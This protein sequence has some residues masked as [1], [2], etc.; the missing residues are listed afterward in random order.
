MD[1]VG[2]DL[3]R[4]DVTTIPQLG[5][6]IYRIRKKMRSLRN[7]SPV[8]REAI[9]I[10]RFFFTATMNGKTRVL[11]Y[12]P[13]RKERELC[14]QC[15]AGDVIISLPHGAT[16]EDGY[17]SQRGLR[18]LL[19]PVSN[20]SSMSNAYIY[21]ATIMANSILEIARYFPNVSP[22]GVIGVHMLDGTRRV[23]HFTEST[24][25]EVDEDDVEID[26]GDLLVPALEEAIQAVG[27][28]HAAKSVTRQTE[29]LH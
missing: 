1:A 17:R 14:G 8:V 11:I 12:D 28:S 26:N 15:P 7:V 23:V 4:A 10:T 3:G 2:R 6:R 24:V 20:F 13:R 22:G 27:R 25:Y 5:K 18:K 16:E 19:R 9:D 21:H 29:L